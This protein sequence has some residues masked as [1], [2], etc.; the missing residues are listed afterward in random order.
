MLTRPPKSGATSRAWQSH[1]PIP[2]H[3]SPSPLSHK[4]QDSKKLE[5]IRENATLRNLKS[6]TEILGNTESKAIAES[7]PM[8]SHSHGYSLDSQNRLFAQKEKGF[9]PSPL[10]KAPKRIKRR[11]FCCAALATRW[12]FSAAKSISFGGR[13]SLFPCLVKNAKNA[14]LHFFNA[15][16]PP[17]QGRVSVCTCV[18]H[19]LFDFCCAKMA[20][21]KD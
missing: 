9:I 1:S 8:D 15:F 7:S 17:R 12:V 21:S 19:I 20:E 13:A 5:N 3:S 10:A 14:L 11:C 4:T 2:A 6:K 18:L 16:L